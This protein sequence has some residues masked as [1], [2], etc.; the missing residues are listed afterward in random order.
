MNLPLSPGAAKALALLQAAGYEAWIV[1]GCVRDALLGLPPKDYDLTTS[2]LPEE[3]QRVF[4]VYP[5]IETGLRH[6]TVTVLL[7]GEPLEITTYR[8]DGVYSDARHPDGVT[9][10]RSLRQDAA[11]RDF[12]INAMAYAPGQ[13]LQDFFGG[14]AD[15]A[16]GILRAVGTA[17]KRFR[18]DALRI[19]R[20]LRFA[21]VLD[22]TLE[23]ETARAARAC[24]PLL[25]AVSA[26]RVSGELGKLLCG[27]AAGRV[28]REYPDVLGVVLPEIL[29]MV[30]LDHRNAYHCYDVWTH[31]AVA[32]DHVPPELPLRLAM[33]LHDIGKPDTFSLG[34]D[35]QGHF[36]GHPR[37]SVELA[38]KILTRL[39]FP[40]RTRE[41]VLTLVRYHDAVLEESPQRVR[42]WL[43]KL[44][45]EVFF[46]LLAIQGGD[47]A[48]Q[49]PAYCTRLD[50]LR[51][52]ETL[53][54]QV[55]DQA[56]CLTVRDLAVG[57]EDL[58]ALGYRGPAIGRALRALLDQVLS[59][60]VSNEKNA[61][62]QR[63]AQMDAENTEKME[64]CSKKKDP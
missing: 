15:L 33:L 26:E 1:G 60:T 47:A 56:P 2:A 10:T 48:A 27:K 42:R 53:A 39:R 61:L 20:A 22:F 18:E 31:T 49:A 55:L 6:G 51:R 45:P 64:P 46:D 29:P 57:G 25:A 32:V 28:L 4:A 8:V 16:R 13:G 59:E 54:R 7:E 38:E 12:T 58:L 36:Y 52:L 30:G 21:S 35:G 9:F 63:L 19:L 62:L 17:E 3:T 24:A 50:H 44:G 34:E 43:N 14:Q 11:R 37:R 23:G 5:R 41:R 40:R